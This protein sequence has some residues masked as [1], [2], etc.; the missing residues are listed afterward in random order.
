MYGSTHRLTGNGC[1]LTAHET[2]NSLE[3]HPTCLCCA[4]SAIIIHV[5]NLNYQTQFMYDFFFETLSQTIFIKLLV[6]E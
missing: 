2:G 5:A 6:T 1:G 3:S 4:V